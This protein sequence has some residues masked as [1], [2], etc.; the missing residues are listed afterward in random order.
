MYTLRAY[1]DY[2]AALVVMLFMVIGLMTVAEQQKKKDSDTPPIGQ[3]TATIVWPEG[4]TDVD[5]WVTGPLQ[6]RPVGYTNS[7]GVA[8]D[9]LRDD[10][11]TADDLLPTNMETAAVRSFSAGNYT[12]NV[13]CFRC[14]ILPVEVS[15]EIR[16]DVAGTTYTAVKKKTLYSNKEEVTMMDFKIDDAGLVTGMND[17][18]VPLANNDGSPSVTRREE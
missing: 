14:P 4:N 16:T 10:R 1:I 13:K 15:M 17:V 3:I 12:L 5:L 18:Y 7:H 6:D 8:W 9:L 11:G 2:L